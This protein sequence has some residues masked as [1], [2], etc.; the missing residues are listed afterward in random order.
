[1][2]VYAVDISALNNF[3]Q[4]MRLA[5]YQIDTIIGL[6]FLISQKM[7]LVVDFSKNLSYFEEI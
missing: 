1:M 4:E 3:S 7:K 2:P 6:D 5:A